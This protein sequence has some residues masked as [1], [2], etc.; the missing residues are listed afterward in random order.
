[1]CDEE[2]LDGQ[3]EVREVSRKSLGIALCLL[4]GMTN[5]WAACVRAQ[6]FS[7]VSPDHWAYD[8]VE[9]TARLGL[10]VGRGD[11]TFKGDDAATRYELA[12]GLAKLLA[13]IENREKMRPAV[14]QELILQ[15]EALNK[16]LAS[17]IDELR[18]RQELII[19]V[20][21]EHLTRT[22]R[23]RLPK[24]LFDLKSTKRGKR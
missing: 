24:D 15:L 5:M 7:D 6:T 9:K 17:R 23:E 16:Y 20:L 8:A 4:V 11:G 1:M 19:A 2:E 14:P 12:M 3:K 10:V 22:H 13:E 21:K 18:K